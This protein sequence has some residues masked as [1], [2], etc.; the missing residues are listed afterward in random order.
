[1]ELGGCTA[2]VRDRLVIHT[3]QSLDHPE[4]LWLVGNEGWAGPQRCCSALV[5]GMG[6]GCRPLC[7]MV[8]QEPWLP[9]P[10]IS[11]QLSPPLPEAATRGLR[12]LKNIVDEDFLYAG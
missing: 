9:L 5:R 2:L 7:R 6:G 8:S 4:P 1:M 11:G 12:P 3:V 10:Q